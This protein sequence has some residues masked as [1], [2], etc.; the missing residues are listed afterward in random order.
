M[1]YV[2]IRILVFKLLGLIWGTL[3]ERILV[4]GLSELS[5]LNLIFYSFVLSAFA[6]RKYESGFY[7]VYLRVDVKRED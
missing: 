1:L 2:D 3:P 4:D 6:M 7:L 5:G